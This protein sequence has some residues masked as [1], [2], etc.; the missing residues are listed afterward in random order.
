MKMAKMTAEEIAAADFSIHEKDLEGYIG[1]G[2]FCR[3]ACMTA[4]LQ[5]W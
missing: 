1:K 3:T 4:L 5:E 2:S